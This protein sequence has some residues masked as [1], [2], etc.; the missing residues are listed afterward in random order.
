MLLLALVGS[1]GGSEEAQQFFSLE[2]ALAYLAIGLW[3]IC[4]GLAYIEKG[5]G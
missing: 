1:S 3:A 2:D 4:H 5:G